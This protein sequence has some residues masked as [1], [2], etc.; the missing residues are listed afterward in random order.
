MNV[1]DER[2]GMVMQGDLHGMSDVRRLCC[3]PFH[4]FGTGPHVALRIRPRHELFE[5][6]M[7]D[8]AACNFRLH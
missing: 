1:E 3:I 5:D 8:A 7:Q 2:G 4:P 6:L